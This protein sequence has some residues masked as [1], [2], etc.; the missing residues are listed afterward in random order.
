MMACQKPLSFTPAGSPSESVDSIYVGGDVTS[1]KRVRKSDWQQKA[2][3]PEMPLSLL[4]PYRPP[5]RSRTSA[6]TAWCMLPNADCASWS[7]MS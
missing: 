7:S 2:N 3:L 4:P 1:A 5:G 6:F